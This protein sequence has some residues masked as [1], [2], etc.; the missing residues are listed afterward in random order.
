[1]HLNFQA[2][3]INFEKVGGKG[4]DSYKNSYKERKKNSL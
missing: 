2:R 1:M 3:C 4:A